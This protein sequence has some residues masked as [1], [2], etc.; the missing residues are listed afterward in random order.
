MQV[1]ILVD[2]AEFWSSL[3]KDL[4]EAKQYAYVQAM[5]F[6]GDSVGMRVADTMKASSARDRRIIV[7]EFYTVHRVNDHYLP[8]PKH[9]L[10]GDLRRERDETVEML[11][12][13]NASGV[14]VKLINSSGWVTE[15]F[16]HRNHKKI[17]VVDDRVAYVGGF[18]FSE[19]NFEWH[20]M[21]LRI[22][23]PDITTFLRDDFLLSWRNVHANTSKKFG[24]IEVF[25]FDGHTN[26]TTFAPI[27]DL[28]GSAQDSIHILS[29]YIT[30]PFFERLRQA[31]KNGARVV[32]ITPDLNNWGVMREYVLWESARAD[33]EVRHY[34]GRMSHLKAL[35]I[36][37]RHLVVGSSNF[38]FLSWQFMQ[39]IVAVVSNAD[40][41]RDFKQRVLDG[42][43]ERSERTEE[44]ISDVR[45]YYHDYRI[46]LLS[47][48]CKTLD[49]IVPVPREVSLK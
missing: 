18:N 25:R 46:K 2:A 13:L 27:L 35:L 43:L 26:Q 7:D 19:H 15:R 32:L 24:D 39:E 8:N 12:D 17:I 42:D 3:E 49:R 37:D 30:Y 28:V 38:D 20:D 4:K 22:D 6:E 11:R 34:A 48:I 33:I 16:L 29:P 47:L 23:S 1:Q 41:I 44:H 5:S 9:W 36:D 40:V 45:G 14:P 31:R 10:R 21:M